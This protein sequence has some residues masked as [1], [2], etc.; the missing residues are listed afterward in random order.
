MAKAKRQMI[1]EP[2]VQP[3][4]QGGDDWTM[5]KRSQGWKQCQ[6]CQAYSKG[7]RSLNCKNPECGEPFPQSKN[8]LAKAPPKKTPLG[9]NGMVQ[10]I[11][12]RIE[13]INSILDVLKN[14]NPDDLEVE[15]DKLQET[16]SIYGVDEE[17]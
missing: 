12:Q 5:E 4:V 14:V 9:A 10:A 6:H 1:V 3:E 13:E 17:D 15:R 11:Y 7:A 16:L 2:K 8:Q